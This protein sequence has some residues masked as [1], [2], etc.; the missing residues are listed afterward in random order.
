MNRKK[1]RPMNGAN[2]VG[3]G[4]VVLDII[5]ENG[6]K[7]P[8]FTAGGTCGNILAGLSFLGWHSK[9]ISR[10]GMD[11]AGD[12]LLQDLIRDGVDVQ[13]LT[14]EENLKTPR[15]VER[16]ETDGEHA[17]H[18]FLLR[19]PSCRRFLPR[20]RSPEVRF[21]RDI[22]ERDS[23]PD[24]YLFDRVTPSTLKLARH[25]RERGALIFF[26]PINLRRVDKLV[27]AVELSHIVKFSGVPITGVPD[28]DENMAILRSYAPPLI[29]QT[30]GEGG[31]LFSRPKDSKWHHR[32]SIKLKSVYD[33]CGAGDWC[34]VGFL[35]RLRFLARKKRL[36]LFEALTSD[37]LVD[38]ALDFGQTLASLSCKFLGAR[39]LSNSMDHRKVLN[40]VSRWMSTN[41]ETKAPSS[42]RGAKN[43]MKQ[44]SKL[45]TKRQQMA[46]CPTCLLV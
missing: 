18:G 7:T 16:V 20:F 4:L 14:K 44:I 36:G 23:V 34:T 45:G 5:V 17:K 43:P 38:G 9:V 3:A 11:L 41:S 25:Y 39:G 27:D 30:L 10:A 12:I 19:C 46:L 15:I 31:L 8:V 6:S 33:S 28:E 35:F 24:V 26:E 40:T 32:S 22:V 1:R 37:S 13:Y 29:I 2:I 42:V 21:I